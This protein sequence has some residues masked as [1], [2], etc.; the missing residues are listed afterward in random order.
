MNDEW[1]EKLR[2]LRCGKTGMASLS[3]DEA[4]E[5]PAVQAIAD[6][7]KVVDSGF[8]PAFYCGDCDIEVA[9]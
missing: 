3:Q 8:G 5:V 7:F 4:H 1:N 9:P 6:G 2:C